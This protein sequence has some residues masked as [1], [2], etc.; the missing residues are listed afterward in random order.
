MLKIFNFR[1]C[2][3]KPTFVGEVFADA[4]YI[5]RIYVDNV[6]RRALSSVVNKGEFRF[7]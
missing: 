5:L 1:E 6:A 7:E 2:I 3:E 4:K